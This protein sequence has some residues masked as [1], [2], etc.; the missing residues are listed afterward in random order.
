MIILSSCPTKGKTGGPSSLCGQGLPDPQ[1]CSFFNFCFP[2]VFTT[3]ALPVQCFLCVCVC[4][5]V[6]VTRLCPTLC[7]PTS[8]SLPGFSVHGI[9]QAR[10]L[11]WIAIP[12]SRE[13]SQPRD[14]TLVSCIA[15][16]F[17][18]IWA[19][20]KQCFLAMI[21]CKQFYLNWKMNV[22]DAHCP[23]AGTALLGACI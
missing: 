3:T 11:E 16:R 17:L 1:H 13:S 19:T 9:L 21:I 5:C 6:L 22:I 4:V 12:F 8:Y 10:I 14:W 2:F 18:I 7:D 23:G 20:G 15:G